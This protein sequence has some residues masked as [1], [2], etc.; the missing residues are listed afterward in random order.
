[1]KLAPIHE[2]SHKQRAQLRKATYLEWLSIAYLCSVSILMYL[3]M[4]ASQAMKTAWIED[5]L[6]IVPPCMFLLT[7]HYRNKTPDKHFPYGYH[8]ITSI[9]YLVSSLALLIVGGYLMVDSTL[10]L[11]H[12]E[13]PTIGM[14]EYF[15]V[16][17]WLGWWM[18]PVLFWGAI[19]PVLLGRAKKKLAEPLYEKILYTDAKMNNADWLTAAAAI[20]GV[21]GI[22]LGLWWADAVAALFICYDIV[23]DGFRQSRDAVTGLMQRAPKELDGNYSDLPERIVRALEEL[24]WVESAKVRLH[25]EGHLIFGEGFYKSKK[26]GPVSNEELREA[27]KRVAAI[28]WR[29]LSFVLA[30]E[31]KEN[32]L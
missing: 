23:K 3:V 13:H 29:L 17:M 26:N 25:E 5:I 22:G 6:S 1:M 12:Q 27:Q 20:V 10:K 11:I 8:G 18:M 24:D 2:F 16:D 31:Q 21:L 9:G 15:G 32:H 7:N 19:P 4:G 14:Q 30:A 28:D